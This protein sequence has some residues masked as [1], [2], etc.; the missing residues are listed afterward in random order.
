MGTVVISID[1]ELAWGFHDLSD[2]PRERIAAARPAWSRLL[3][4]LEEF[5]IPA[6]WAIVG[7]LFLEEC[8]GLHTGH[9]G[10]PAWFARDP[11]GTA[12]EHDEWFGPDLV[13]AVRDSPVG[14]E[15]ACHSFSHVQFGDPETTR[16][17]AAA[18]VEA[19]IEAADGTGIE[20]HSF[21]FPRNK[22]GHRD[23]LAAY[24]IRSYRG[25]RPRQW[26]DT[27]R[28]RRTGKFLDA[29]LVRSPPPLVSPSVDEYGLVNLPASL[30]LFGF[31]GLARRVL[32][33]TVGDPVVRQARAG[34]DRA[35]ESEGVFHCWLHPN[36]L[37]TERDVERL[38]RVL[39]YLAARR[40]S[41]PLTV[42]TMRT[43]SERVDPVGTYP[44]R[45]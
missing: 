21:V 12:G 27:P 42:E 11:G 30:D 33:S 28:A 13:R 15:I 35:V 43:V 4:L 8:D 45:G 39:S 17:L 5:S 23:V 38:R 24:G 37:L 19:S 18:E 44:T 29:A 22:V 26:F 25:V 41:T 10:S 9:P 40:E 6:T 31:E 7:H 2:P 36:N 32:T 16:E 3:S 20:L 34:I 14:H 1:A